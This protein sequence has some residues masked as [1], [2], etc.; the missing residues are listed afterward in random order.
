MS[1]GIGASTQRPDGLAKAA[2]T[3]VFAGDLSE[4]DMLW[5]AVL[6][7]PYPHA[8]LVALDVSPAFA[9]PGVVSVLSSHDVPGR[10]TY[11]LDDPD[12]PVFTSDVARFHGEPVVAV[13]ATSLTAAREGCAA[14][15]VVWERLAPVVDTEEALVGPP[16]HPDGNLYRRIHLQKGDPDVEGEIAVEQSYVIGTQDQAFLGTEAALAMPDGKGGVLLRVATQDLHA[17]R[18]QIAACL[19][20]EP[21]QVTITLG[22]VG[23]A[24]GGREDM[25]LQVHVCM[26]ALDTGRPVKMVYSREESFLGH[27]HRHAM[28]LHYRTTADRDGRL[29]SQRARILLDGGAYAS[30]TGPVS[31]NAATMAAGP[32]VIPNVTIDCYGVRTNNPPSGAMRGFGAVQVCAAYEAQ[33]D[34]LAAAAGLD[35]LEVR[36]RNALSTGETLATGQ[37]VHSAAPVQLLIDTVA[38]MPLPPP[39]S[40]AVEDLPGGPAADPARVRRGVG[41]ALGFKNIAFSEGFD[42]PSTALVRLEVDASGRTQAL[43]HCAAAE[44]GQGFVTI[45]EQIVRTELGVD[46]VSMLDADTLIGPAGSTSASRQ[47]WVSGGAVQLACAAVSQQ[48]VQRVATASGVPAAS[49]LLRDGLVVSPE[50]RLRVTLAEALAAGPVEAERTFR[51]RKTSP[52]DARGQGDAHVAWSFVIH[53]AVVDVDLDLGTVRLVQL[54]TV[55]DVGKALN[56][57]SVLGQLEGGTAQGVGFALTEE[58][59]LEGGFVIHPTF[60]EYLIPNAVDLPMLQVVLVEQPEPDAPFG[61]KGVGEAPTVSSPAAV[62]AAMRAATGLP[63]THMPVRAEHLAA[64]ADVPWATR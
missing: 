33:M 47:T 39:W 5:G 45:V 14:V 18:E 50:A 52:L 36:R 55:Q 34:L 31:A 21:E 61:A 1:R 8:R 23:G 35:P 16:L 38:E 41:H 25:S 17:D 43:V 32:Y 62:M 27:V 46:E 57:L 51:H 2:G 20:L 29:V 15:T 24:F 59:A 49:C 42:D 53:R 64:G 26:L 19:A 54:A 22:G 28:R 48:L 10:A 9:V 56:P 37:V 40:G 3:F 13:A 63:L 60:S 11:G 58:L 30:T 6:R 4:P 44:V 7:C 12:Q